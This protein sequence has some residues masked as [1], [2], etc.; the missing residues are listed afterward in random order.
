MCGFIT[1]KVEA[2]GFVAFFFFY[3]KLE[4]DEEARVWMNY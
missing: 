4:I 3:G 2:R 1:S